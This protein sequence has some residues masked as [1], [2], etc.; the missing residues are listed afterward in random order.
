[1]AL[2]DNMAAAQAQ[3][4]DA[5]TSAGYSLLKPAQQRLTRLMTVWVLNDR[6][7]GTKKK[8][9]RMEDISVDL[10]RTMDR[11]STTMDG[12]LDTIRYQV[13][14]PFCDRSPRY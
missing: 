2:V 1:M 12:I 10:L 9:L 8:P 6:R 11:I 5:A 13:D 3:K 14:P 7:R 4:N